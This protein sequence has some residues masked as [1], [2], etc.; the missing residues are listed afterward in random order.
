MCVA[1]V[2]LR[3]TECSSTTWVRV[4]P[5]GNDKLCLVRPEGT[6]R[7]YAAA[8]GHKEAMEA[9][10]EFTAEQGAWAL[11]ALTHTCIHTHTHARA[12]TQARASSMSTHSTTASNECT[13]MP[14]GEISVVRTRDSYEWIV[15]RVAVSRDRSG[16]G[17]T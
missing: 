5:M 16:G 4:L 1:F 13:V 10:D 11:S 14:C 15:L 9:M 2:L 3:V 7:S 12:H 17:V 8:R 6:A